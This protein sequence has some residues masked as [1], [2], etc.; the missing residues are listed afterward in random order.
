MQEYNYWLTSQAYIRNSKKRKLINTF[1]NAKEVFETK[2]EKYIKEGILNLTEAMQLSKSKASFDEKSIDK[3]SSIGISF[4]TEIDKD[5]PKDL[6]PIYDR[7]FGLFYKGTLP[8]TNS[9]NIAIVG[10]RNATA[11]GRAKTEELVNALSKDNVTIISGMARGIDSASHAR[12]LLNNMFTVAVL[13]CGVDICYPK[14][15]YNIYENIIKNGCI[16]S[17]FPPGTPPLSFNFPLRN[18]IISALSKVVIVVEAKNRSGSL[19]TAD[20]ALEQGKEVFALPGRIDDILSEGCNRLIAQGAGIITSVED[21]IST[22][23]DLSILSHSKNTEDK[24]EAL[25]D[26]EKELLEIIDIY[27]TGL[28][29]IIEKSN[30][31]LPEILSTLRLLCSKGLITEEIKNNYSKIK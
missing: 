9:I 25:F 26:I 5:Y 2:K 1:G 27:P 24:K 18:R 16:L 7:P 15:N 6:L 31:S 11:Y 12:A 28:N 3:L 21:F 30:S 10:A 23:K 29:E 13:G 22:L 17:E 14:E 20:Y 19:I 4:I 8:K